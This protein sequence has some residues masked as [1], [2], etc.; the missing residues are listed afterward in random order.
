MKT[1]AD[2]KQKQIAQIDMKQ[3]DVRPLIDG[4]G[5]AAFQ[6]R[7]LGRAAKIYDQMLRDPDCTVILTLAGS[8]FGAGL[9]KIVYDMVRMTV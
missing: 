3:V 6:A 1:K 5:N 8:L 7:N 9:K 2:Y 4:M